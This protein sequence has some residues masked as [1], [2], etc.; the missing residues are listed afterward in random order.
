LN[1]QIFTVPENA[2][3]LQE[4]SIQGPP[5]LRSYC[6]II[7]YLLIRSHLSQE[8]LSVRL[9]Q[10]YKKATLIDEGLGPVE[11]KKAIACWAVV[12]VEVK[13]GKKA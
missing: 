9:I 2:L 1:L 7:G 4:D 11:G 12:L 13:A 10:Q 6:A 3:S 5:G 8:I